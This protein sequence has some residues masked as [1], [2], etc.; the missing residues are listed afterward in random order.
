[1]RQWEAFVPADEWNRRNALFDYV[2]G[3]N[4]A[5]SMRDALAAIRLGCIATVVVSEEH[6]DAAGLVPELRTEGFEVRR[7]RGFVIATLPR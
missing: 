2:E 4:G 3:G 7:L 5:M 6:P 1:M